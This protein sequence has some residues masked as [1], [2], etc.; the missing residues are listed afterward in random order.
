MGYKVTC[1]VTGRG[2]PSAR[3][4]A[5]GGERDGNEE[6]RSLRRL[7]PGGRIGRAALQGQ[8]EVG[9]PSTNVVASSAPNTV[10]FV[11]HALMLELRHAKE[12]LWKCSRASRAGLL[13][14]SSPT[15]LSGS[16][17][18]RGSASGRGLMRSW[19]AREP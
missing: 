15:G 12:W 5:G 8:E 11:P 2:E 14:F 7:L 18:R 17:G 9:E 3:Y 4:R 6:G 1:D 13:P 10:R 16:L 19:P